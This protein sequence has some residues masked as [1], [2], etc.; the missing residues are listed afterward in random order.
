MADVDKIL[1]LVA[2][3]SAEPGRGRRDPLGDAPQRETARDRHRGAGQGRPARHLRIEVTEGGRRVVNLRV[4]MNIAGWASSFL[5]G[6]SDD[7][8]NR[9]RGRDRV[10]RA[11]PNPRHQQPRRQ[12]R[13]DR[14]RIT[15]KRNPEMPIL[16]SDLEEP[17][18]PFVTG[19][20]YSGRVHEIRRRDVRIAGHGGHRSRPGPRRPGSRGPPGPHDSQPGDPLAAESARL[21]LAVD[22]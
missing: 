4:P 14:Q 7:H 1:R 11:R 8:A 21:P 6:L 16:N 2:E 3:G 19:R 22:R 17:Y 13:A 10:R 18:V 12:P 5:P 15:R 20:N 9:I